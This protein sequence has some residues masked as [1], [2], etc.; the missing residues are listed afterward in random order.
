MKDKADIARNHTDSNG[1]NHGV[2]DGRV[3]VEKTMEECTGQNRPAQ[4]TVTP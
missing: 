2:E 3:S 1:L 4:A